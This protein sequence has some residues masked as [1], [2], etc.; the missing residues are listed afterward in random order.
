MKFKRG[1]RVRYE[2]N[3][4]GSAPRWDY[5][6]DRGGSGKWF[7]GVVCEVCADDILTDAPGVR[8]W[9]WPN[10]KDGAYDED[11]WSRPGFLQLMEAEVKTTKETDLQQIS[12][13]GLSRC[14]ACAK[15]TKNIGGFSF[16][17]QVCNNPKCQAYG[18]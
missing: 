5:G 4:S 2:L 17:Y 18:R 15:P 12:N 16:T 7:E 13:Q 11:Q 6:E 10:V 8:Y 9:Y 14:M 3:L 1:D